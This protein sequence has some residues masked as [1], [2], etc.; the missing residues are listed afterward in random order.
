LTCVL[1]KSG[2]IRALLVTV[3]VPIT[4][5]TAALTPSPKGPFNLFTNVH[6][7]DR[8]GPLYQ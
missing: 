1:P 8:S 7:Q 3:N 4:I 5:G 2:I 6:L